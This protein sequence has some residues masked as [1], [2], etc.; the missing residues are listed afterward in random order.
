MR[1]SC[2]QLVGLLCGDSMRIKLTIR[3]DG[4]AYCG[5]QIQP[6]GISVQEVITNAIEAVTGEK[7]TLVGS[8][9]TDSGVH[10]EGQIAHFD[11]QSSIPPNKFFRAINVH[12][13]SDIRIIDSQQVGED[14]NA[15]KSAKQKTYRYTLYVDN[16]ENPLKDRYMTFLDRMP[17]IEKMKKASS[18]FIGEH[19]F[20]CFNASGGGA[21][22]TVR[23]IYN[24]DIKNDD[25]IKIFVTGNG[26]LY[27]MVR[28]LCGTLLSVGYGEKNEEDI[29]TLLLLGDRKQCGKTLP[30]KGLCLVNVEYK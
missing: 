2:P 17:D 5:W 23:T 7:V 15:R 19:D 10:A 30:A 25:G 1:N 3:Y 6:N 4:S 11:T 20:K 8:G 27:N 12:L 21:K 28:T 16:T 29:K 14:F 9:R 18:L 24:I 13:P 22:T 26:F